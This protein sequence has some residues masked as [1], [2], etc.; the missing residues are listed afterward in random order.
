M[1]V[2]T[3]RTGRLVVADAFLELLRIHGLDSFEALVSFPGGRIVR[4]KGVRQI[5]KIKL[6]EPEPVSLYLKQHRGASF[7]EVFKEVLR[8][9]RP[10]SAAAREWRAISLLAKAGVPTMSPVAYG[11][12]R[13]LPWAG[14]SCIA[15]LEVE[16]ERLEDR[17]HLLRGK[18]RE[19]RCIITLLADLV[20]TMHGAGLNHRDLYLCH[21]FLQEKGREKSLTLID[22]QRLQRRARGF[23]RWVVK[24]LAALNYSSPATAVTRADRVRFLRR[25][26]RLQKLDAA[27]K[28]FAARISRKTERI[29][30]HDRNLKLRRRKGT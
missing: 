7:R 18:Y 25:Y 21:V 1:A 28:R 13:F 22:L 10:L 14:P 8:G 19:K 12:R 9:R 16:G 4:D 24:D 27:A 2:L 15:T 23:N 26:L 30:R 6:A 11:E 3:D 17:A 29:R 20:R 5:R